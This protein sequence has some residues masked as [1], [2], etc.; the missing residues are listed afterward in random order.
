MDPI[1]FNKEGDIWICSCPLIIKRVY[2][3]FT[4]IGAR[5]VPNKKIL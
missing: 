5:F 3:F 1:I 2:M 4:M